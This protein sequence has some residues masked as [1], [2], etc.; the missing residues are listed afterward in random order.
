VSIVPGTKTEQNLINDVLDA[1]LEKSP[2]ALKDMDKLAL[3]VQRKLK[4]KVDA[5]VVRSLL[6][7]SGRGKPEPI[8]PARRISTDDVFLLRCDKCGTQFWYKEPK[9]RPCEMELE[10]PPAPGVY[11]RRREP[12]KMYSCPGVMHATPKPAGNSFGSW[13]QLDDRRKRILTNG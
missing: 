2:K 3:R 11:L 7:G 5:S 9:S 10:V 12:I 1:I 8:E 4:G 13:A 6:M